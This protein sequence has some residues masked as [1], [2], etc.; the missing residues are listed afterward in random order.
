MDRIDRNA[1]E[2]GA[3]RAAPA[4]ARWRRAVPMAFLL[5]GTVLF[6]ALG[7]GRYL[8]LDALASNH[9]ELAGFVDAH[10]A[11]AVLIYVLAYAGAVAVSVPGATILTVTGGVLFGAV[12]GA[13]C[14]TLGATIGAVGVFLAARTAVGSALRGRAGP[15]VTRLEA[16]F[17]ADAFSYLLFLRLVPLFPFWLVNLVPACLEVGLGVYAAAT[18]IGIMP[19]AFIYAS[20]GSGLGAV[21]DAGGRP[22]L[23]I[24][25][26]PQLL[27]PIL[28]LAVLALV[29]VVV[30]HRRRSGP[31]HP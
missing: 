12:A 20:L 30:R 19:A 31:G 22:D 18:V 13:A 9:R 11:L 1:G 17:R 26:R 10:A 28:G 27:G 21:V 16:G 24:I 7:F 2:D 4:G 6:F 25:F 8:S 29:P 3:I 5:S 14:A 15:W 23:A